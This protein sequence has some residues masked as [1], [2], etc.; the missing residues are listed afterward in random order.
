MVEAIGVPRQG[1][2]SRR[3]LLSTAGAAMAL[4]TAPSVAR[5]AKPGHNPP[6]RG[7]DGSILKARIY[8]INQPANRGPYPEQAHPRYSA[9]NGKWGVSFSGGG[10]RSY[11]ASVGQMRALLA[12]GVEDKIGAISC[13]SGAS[14]FGT[15]YTFAPQRYSDTNLLGPIVQPGALTVD[16]L[17]QIDP[18]SLGARITNLTDE[19][20]LAILATEIVQLL[21]FGYIPVDKLYSRLLNS[22]FLLPY[23][24]ADTS[25]LFTLNQASAQAIR[26]RNPDLAGR[27][28]MPRAGRPFLIVGGT[29]IYQPNQPQQT[30][31]AEI[32]A[33]QVFRS[34]EYTPLYSGAPQLVEQGPPTNLPYGGGYVESFA[35]DT[36]APTSRSG[37][38]AR[39]PQGQYPFLLSDMMGSSSASVAAI[40]AQKLPPPFSGLDPFPS[41]DYWPITRVGEVS[42]M[43]YDFGDGGI[44]EDTGVI[45]LLRRGYRTI[46]AFVNSSVPINSTSP[47]CVEGIDGQISRLFGFIPS[48]NEG[49]GQSTQVFASEQFAALAN[50]LKATRAAGGAPVYVDRFPVLAGNPFGVAP[51]TPKIFWLYNDLNQSWFSQLP[52]SVQAL[53]SNATYNLGDFPNYA[54]FDQNKDDPIFLSAT[55]VNLLA[56]MWSYSVQTGFKRNGYAFGVPIG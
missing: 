12:T 4:A 41:F 34:I 32:G 56:N 7:S 52:S 29:Q 22:A 43:E 26:A 10:S 2:L 47:I 53:F 11:S 13:V 40:V 50:G 27:F 42:A 1:E 24:L 54:T 51:Y 21:Q 17:N 20:L 35:F 44:L 33:Q 31:V 23:N 39:V 18:A 16:G 8:P 15:P 25:T 30:P 19:Y 5:A 49:N 46:F 38:I 14:W 45:P 55:Q 36:P 9:A 28:Y 48:N 6:N 3:Q 37:D